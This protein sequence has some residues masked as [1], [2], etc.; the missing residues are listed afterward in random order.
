MIYDLTLRKL[1]ILW[2][3]QDFIKGSCL[4]FT[5]CVIMS[6]VV[7]DTQVHPLNIS[8]PNQIIAEISLK[9]IEIEIKYPIILKM[10]IVNS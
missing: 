4:V 2:R 9:S 5:M 8:Q 6:M 1:L 3:K 7:F 10:F